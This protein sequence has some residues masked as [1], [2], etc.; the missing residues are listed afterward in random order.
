MWSAPLPSDVATITP[1]VYMYNLAFGV[2][3]GKHLQKYGYEDPHGIMGWH[4]KRVLEITEKYGLDAM[5]WSDMYFQLDGGSYYECGEPSQAAKD[6]VDPKATLVYWDYYHDDPDFYEDM[7][8]KHRILSPKTAFAG[9]LW[10]WS[11][12]AIDYPVPLPTPF[13]PWPLPE[14]MACRRFLPP[15]GAMTVR[16]P[17]CFPPCWACSCMPS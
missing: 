4:L 1:V 5:M 14:N 2:G 16:K 10:N 15:C 3:L 17:I 8:R 11:G 7:L 12:P 9:G 13:P 6:A